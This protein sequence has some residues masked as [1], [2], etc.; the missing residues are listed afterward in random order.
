M[1]ANKILADL[2]RDV[3]AARVDIEVQGYV[4]LPE[5]RKILSTFWMLDM[6]L[7]GG[8]TPPEEW[9]EG[10]DAVGECAHDTVVMGRCDTCGE[11]PHGHYGDELAIVQLPDGRLD[12]AEPLGGP[13]PGVAGSHLPEIEAWHGRMDARDSTK[14]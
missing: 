14:L 5:V 7:S 4:N 1:D 11:Y 8:G 3:Q 12:I 6:H 9:R 2:R 10:P 13:I